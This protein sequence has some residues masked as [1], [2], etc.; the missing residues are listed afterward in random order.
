MYLVI[1]P[2]HPNSFPEC[3]FLGQDSGM[4]KY[5]KCEY[6]MSKCLSADIMIVITSLKLYTLTKNVR[7]LPKVFKVADSHE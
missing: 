3:R 1:D 2:V 6:V 7:H 4:F 5:S